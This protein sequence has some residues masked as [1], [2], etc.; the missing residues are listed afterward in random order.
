MHLKEGNIKT[1]L[2]EGWKSVAWIH[3]AEDKGHRRAP[4]NRSLANLRY[5][6]KA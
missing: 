1:V 3:L 5:P 2:K 6:Y 4:V